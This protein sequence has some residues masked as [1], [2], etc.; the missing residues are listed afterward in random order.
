MT[1]WQGSHS[2]GFPTAVRQRILHRDPVCRC[3]GC[4]HHTGHCTAPST[5]ADHIVPVADGGGHSETNGRGMC[6]ICH[7]VT[8]LAHATAARARLPRATRDPETHP[9]LT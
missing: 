9:G 8:T 6:T 2:Q 1:A 5:E 7:L 4:K 3:R